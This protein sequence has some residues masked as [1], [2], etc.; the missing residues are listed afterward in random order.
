MPK[1]NLAAIDL[2]TNSCR[3]LI[4]D[5]NGQEIYRESSST[6]LGEGMAEN[7]C[8]TDAAIERGVQALSHFAEIMRQKN[9]AHYQAIAT[10]ACRM[11]ENGAEFVNIVKEI[12]GVKL[13]VIDAHLEALLTLQGAVLNADRSKKYVL[14][15][16]LGGGSTEI[17]LATNTA[18]PQI[19][20]TLSIPFGAR[21]ASEK[22]GIIE[23]D[24]DKAEKLAAEIKKY[25]DVF[26]SESKLADY[27]A[28]CCCVATSSPALRMMCM[29]KH[30]AVYDRFYADGLTAD[31]K[32]FD[33]TIGDIYKMSF[34]DMAENANIGENRA[35]IFVAGAII[36]Q[37]IYQNL[38]V[39]EI[40]A[41]LKGAVEA[42]CA[43]L[44][45]QWQN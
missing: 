25:V 32:E 31:V 45:A 2:G 21:N 7:N 16:D 11:A 12:C 1:Q 35:A 38:Q 26:V 20:Y 3:L 9:V 29:I 34:A 14:V 40:T 37:T 13:E 6:R 4:T 5:K 43:E 10:A 8:F 28:D 22:F 17:T 15:Y 42:V 39:A 24:A 41:S 36:F 30:T 27:L 19:L 18:K 44:R 23:Y 33:R